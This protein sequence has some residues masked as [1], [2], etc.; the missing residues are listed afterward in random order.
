MGTAFYV[1]PSPILCLYISSIDRKAIPGI[2]RVDTS[3]FL[4]AYAIDNVT[5]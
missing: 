1:L 2:D 4:T 5:R 3:A